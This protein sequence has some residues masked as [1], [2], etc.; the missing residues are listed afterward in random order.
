MEASII[1]RDYID[2][3]IGESLLK[4]RIIMIAEEV[5]PSL[6]KTVIAKLLYLEAKS[7]DPINIYISSP[8]GDVPAGLSIIDAMHLCKCK[9][10]TYA[11]GDCDSMGFM[12]LA[13][14][15][16]KRRIYPHAFTMYHEVWSMSMGHTTTL[17]TEMK[18]TEALQNVLFDLI[19]K[20]TKLT[21]EDLE[22][23]PV[24]TWL[25]AEE[26]VKYGIVDE[27]L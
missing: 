27:I 3:E 9:V 25:T 26:S 18:H 13:C 7:S 12:I 11:I 23:G 10:N 19:L 1:Q 22:K 4:N 6:A 20:H 14:A 16:G 8:G 24:D 21:R 2:G 5:S 15:T 17:K